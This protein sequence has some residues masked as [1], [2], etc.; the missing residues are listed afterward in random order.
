[1]AGLELVKEPGHDYFW[2]NMGPQHPSTHGVFRVLLKLEGEVI[3]E[4]KPV[5]GYLHRGT[6]KIAENRTYFMVVPYMDRLDYVA[7]MGCNLGLCEAVEKMAGIE[8]PQR[9]KYLRVIACE[10]NRIAS[11]LVWLG[12]WGL[13]LGVLTPFLYCFRERERVIYLLEMMSGAR[14]T[15]NYIQYGGV[16][17]DI[18]PEFEPVCRKFLKEFPAHIDEYEGLL[19]ENEIF[20]LRTKYVGVLSRELAIQFSCSGPVLRGSGVNWDLRKNQPYCAY[21]EFDFEVPVGENGDCYDRY[22]V[23]ME[24]MRQSV[25]L[26]QQALDGLPDGPYTSK[27]G[28]FFKPSK[29]EAY[30]AVEN[31][32]G[33]FGIYVVS[34]GSPKPYRVKIRSPSFSNIS[35]LPELL[36]GCKIADCVAIMGSLD[37]VFG[38]VDR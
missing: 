36:K 6:E 28:L 15:Y 4:A 20:R 2:L 21:S 9:A 32:R 23:R 12:T 24:E 38:D 33:E 11:H 8:V 10:L 17:D 29:G 22:K 34:D 14:L 35:V 5:I 26:V 27:V 37:P 31:P 3:T 25:R 13:D 18:I 7:A 1:M 16:R 19:G 30:A